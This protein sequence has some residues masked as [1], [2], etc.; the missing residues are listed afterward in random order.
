MSDFRFTVRG[1]DNVEDAEQKLGRKLTDEELSSAIG[2]PSEGVTN[3]LPH[4]DW[5]VIRSIGVEHRGEDIPVNEVG[6]VR[7]FI[8][9]IGEMVLTIVGDFLAKNIDVVEVNGTRFKRED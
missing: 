3:H 7:E 6:A 1:F 5:H 9:G 2:L 8:P 4:S